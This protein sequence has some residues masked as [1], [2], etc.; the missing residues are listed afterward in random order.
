MT[1]NLPASTAK[2]PP[3][4]P[5]R[6]ASMQ[7][8][9]RTDHRRAIA[10]IVEVVLHG[11][12]QPNDAEEMRAAVLRDWCDTLEDWPAQSVRAALSKW[13][14]DHPDKRPNPGHIVG[15]LKDAWGKRNAPGVSAALAP[16]ETPKERVSEE[17]RARILAETGG[18]P[19]QVFKTVA[20]IQPREAAE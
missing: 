5:L 6:G 4:T 15:L 3:L 19:A 13:R 17:A 7:P 11:Y 18:L 12:W 1:A 8:H 14:E 16:A 10:G 9:E 2:L 20:G